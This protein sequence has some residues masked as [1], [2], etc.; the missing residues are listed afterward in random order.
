MTVRITLDPARRIGK[1]PK[2]WRSTGFTP[3]ELLLLPEMH[4]TLDYLAALPD[5][6]VEFL[7]VHYLL[8]L[9]RAQATPLGHRYDWSLLDEALDAMVSR[10]MRPF[11]EIMG[12]P[13]GLFAGFEDRDTLHRWR[14]MVA[15]LARRCIGR[16]GAAEIRAWYFESWNEPD[17]PWWPWGTQAYLNYYDACVEGLGAVDAGLRI[18]GPGTARPLSD[19]FKAFVAHCDTGTNILTGAQGVRLDFVSVHEKGAIKHEEDLTPDTLGIVAREMDAVRW[20]R[21]HHPRLAGLPFINNECDPQVGWIIPHTW[22]AL[23]YFGALIV[24]IVDQHQRLMA[25]A[26]GVD[27]ALL[28]NDNGFIGR[29][30]H[31]TLMTY[32]GDRTIRAAQAEH[33]TDLDALAVERARCA[34]FDLVK[35]PA[36]TV[37]EFL[38]VLGPDRIAVEAVPPLDPDRLGLGVMATARGDGLV[39]LLYNSVDR[40]WSSGR[41]PVDLVLHGLAPGRHVATVLALDDA[42]GTAFWRWEAEG[43][44]A[45]PDARQ[46]AAMRAAE[47][48]GIILSQ[49]IESGPTPPVLRFDVALPS[50]CAVVV[51]P[52]DGSLRQ[53]VPTAPRLAT[54]RSAA[55]TEDTL[56]T[57]DAPSDGRVIIF[58]VLYASTASD[59]LRPVAEGLLSRIF[60]HAGHAGQGRYAIRARALDGRV[61]G[62]CSDQAV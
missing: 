4:R 36:L 51:E 41:T 9:V 17:L 44:P 1:Q 48:V 62:Q 18:G 21:A 47:N 38:S 45:Q 59:P 55:G 43:A 12:N 11:F 16:Y 42:H 2:F 60:L 49:P 61:L 26:E 10:G 28:S 53:L 58:D 31:R 6:G 40:I 19:M 27:Y 8:N 52:L 30:G 25:D 33:A 39:A 46:L 50:V 23:P 5:R 14:D 29:W 37:M 13:S 35:K 24:K 54:H 7:R 34:A 22:H 20:L 57:W 32:F 3:A 15:E 56:L